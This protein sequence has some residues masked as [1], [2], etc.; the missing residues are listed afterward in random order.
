M[1]GVR[2]VQETFSFCFVG[3][4]ALCLGFEGGSE[5]EDTKFVFGD[6]FFPAS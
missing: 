6:V 4:E 2:W 5:W 3:D 1:E